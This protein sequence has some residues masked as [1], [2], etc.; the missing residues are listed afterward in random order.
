MIQALNK[1]ISTYSFR[2]RVL[3]VIAI[4]FVLYIPYS[5]PY[6][7][8][9]A[10]FG[11]QLLSCTLHIFLFRLTIKHLYPWAEPSEKYRSMLA[12]III[13][14]VLINLIPFSQGYTPHDNGFFSMEEKLPQTNFGLPH[15]YL[16]VF[17]LASED[18]REYELPSILFYPGT[19]FSNAFKLSLL[20]ALFVRMRYYFKGKVFL[21]IPEKQDLEN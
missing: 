12:G 4:A 15:I 5:L 21:W 7:K 2:G 20:T 3:A 19:I 1:R 16:R 9:P 13:L 17:H 6:L 10:S 11:T 14:A 18:L 8:S